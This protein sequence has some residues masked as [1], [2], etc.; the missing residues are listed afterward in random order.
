MCAC[1]IVLRSGV[2]SVISF[3]KAVLCNACRDNFGRRLSNPPWLVRYNVNVQNHIR[4]VRNLRPLRPNFSLSH[5]FP[6]RLLL[7]FCLAPSPCKLGGSKPHVRNSNVIASTFL[8]SLSFK[9]IFSWHHQVMQ[10]WLT[11]TWCITCGLT[12]HDLWCNHRKKSLQFCW[13]LACFS[14]SANFLFAWM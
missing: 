5:T 3:T 11:L 14:S 4:Y 1:R 7:Y 9:V 2:I 12:L 6:S 13:V 10:F 8:F